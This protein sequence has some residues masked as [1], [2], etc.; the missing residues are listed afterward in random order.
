MSQDPFSP[1][2]D[3]SF[4]GL[5]HLS[6]RSFPTFFPPPHRTV[7]GL[8]QIQA[9]LGLSTTIHSLSALRSQMKILLLTV[10]EILEIFKRRRIMMVMEMVVVVVTVVVMV[11]A[12]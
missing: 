1:H 10:L 12:H 3:V 8:F 6:L 9:V 2:D 4:G 11:V 5:S 7:S